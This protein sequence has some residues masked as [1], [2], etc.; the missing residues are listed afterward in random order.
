[1]NPTPPPKHQHQYQCLFYHIRDCYVQPTTNEACTVE[2]M[3][4]TGDCH[5]P[6]FTTKSLRAA[7]KHNTN[8]TLFMLLHTG[9][10]D[11]WLFDRLRRANASNTIP[12]ID[13]WKLKHVHSLP[14][15]NLH[16]HNKMSTAIIWVVCD[17]RWIPAFYLN[18]LP[19]IPRPTQI[20]LYFW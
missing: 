4:G 1:M 6:D 9:Q 19:Q 2:T 16:Q 12:R 7:N 3:F 20:P 5:E 18:V 13:C 17:D 15:P 11:K 10:N 14:T 8:W